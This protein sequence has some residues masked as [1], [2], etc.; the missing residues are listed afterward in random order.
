LHLRNIVMEIIKLAAVRQK[1]QKGRI[2]NTSK[3]LLQVAYLDDQLNILDWNNINS[4]DT[5]EEEIERSLPKMTHYLEQA[6]NKYENK[7]ENTQNEIAREY[8][9]KSLERVP[10]WSGFILGDD[11]A[12]YDWKQS[13]AFRCIMGVTLLGQE[14]RPDADGLKQLYQEMRD[15]EPKAGKKAIWKRYKAIVD[16]ID[17]GVDAEEDPDILSKTGWVEVPGGRDNL[18]PNI[19]EEDVRNAD[20]K[21]ESF[22]ERVYLVKRISDGSGWCLTQDWRRSDYVAGGKMLFYLESGR[23]KLCCRYSGQIIAEIQGLNNQ[24]INGYLFG[25]KIVELHEKYPDLHLENDHGGLS[26]ARA[27]RG[28]ERVN[29]FN[30]MTVEQIIPLMRGRDGNPFFYLLDGTISDFLR[31]DQ[32][33][34]KVKYCLTSIGIVTNVEMSLHLNR[35]PTM[36]DDPDIFN[37]VL[38]IT[39]TDFQKVFEW[40]EHTMGTADLVALNKTMRGTIAQHPDIQAL[41]RSTMMSLLESEMNEDI[42]NRLVTLDSYLQGDLRDN[43]EIKDLANRLAIQALIDGDLE[44]FRKLQESFEIA[45]A[46]GD[47][48][49]QAYAPARVRA[50]RLIVDD[51]ASFRRLDEF[52]DNRLSEDM[53]AILQDAFPHAKTVAMTYLNANDFTDFGSLSSRFGDLLVENAEV[54]AVGRE[55]AKNALIHEDD[56]R[57]ALVNDAFGGRM[58]ADKESVIDDV[59]IAL[60]PKI[61]KILV[62]QEAVEVNGEEKQALDILMEYNEKLN[63][64]VLDDENLL[65]DT[66]EMA[67][68]RSLYLLDWGVVKTAE[69]DWLKAFTMLNSTFQGRV[70]RD[71]RVQAQAKSLATKSLLYCDPSS[72]EGCTNLYWKKILERLGRIYGRGLI[73]RGDLQRLRAEHEVAAYKIAMASLEKGDA[74]QMQL[75]VNSFP[76]LLQNRHLLYSAVSKAVNLLSGALLYDPATARMKYEE[77]DR[78]F[79]GQLSAHPRVQ[80][81]L[82]RQAGSTWYKFYRQSIKES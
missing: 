13:H 64:R 18:T 43:Q 73:T 25:D 27:Q 75:L 19:H 10:L 31:N 3:L 39:K 50:V 82:N 45:D 54:Y 4:E 2:Q 42:M 60:K 77:W 68:E 11:A 9:E 70:A 14:L 76:S 40:D 6:S 58:E 55:I 33:K 38:G 16:A 41:G 17:E 59:Y 30:A 1:I 61:Q 80:Q 67:V 57:F 56:D 74:N 26:P 51:M 47:L 63:N 7:I 24:D 22:N 78:V 79:Q 12:E 71:P 34:D 32:F 72:P 66:F 36:K 81:Q 15:S 37:R 62:N 23:P 5:M 48:K 35:F 52:F 20:P 29:Q 44:K 46:D 28:F 8:A 69:D 49:E 21:Y 53:D 65:N